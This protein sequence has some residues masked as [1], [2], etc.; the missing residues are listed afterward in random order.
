MI[1]YDLRCSGGHAFDGWFRDS[2]NFDQQAARGLVECPV[3]GGN[4]VERALMAPRLSRGLGRRS[5]GPV[6]EAEPAGQ[7]EA[8]KP[9]ADADVPPTGGPP[10][11]MPDQMRVVLQRLRA[12]VEQTC[13]YVGGNFAE[14]ARRMHE[15]EKPPKPIYGEATP[16]EAEALAE[17]GIDVARIPWVPR[18]DS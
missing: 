17:D 15:G 8:A 4:T 11:P 2:A 18:A 5:R 12:E 3:C 6:I 16:A 1:H 7:G 9:T 10:V 13:T 14:E